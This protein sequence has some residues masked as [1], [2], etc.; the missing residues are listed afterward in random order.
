MA[1]LPV[2]VKVKKFILQ[3]FF[4]YYVVLFKNW[5]ESVHILVAYDFA[6]ISAIYI[7]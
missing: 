1:A 3:Y 5:L 2:T 6:Y 4:K 7:L